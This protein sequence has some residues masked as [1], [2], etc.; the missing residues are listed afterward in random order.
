[1]RLRVAVAA[2]ASI[3]VNA[4]RAPTDELSRAEAVRRAGM[5]M[6][7]PLGPFR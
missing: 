3:H 6:E 5:D 1:M 4:E 7:Q 2:L